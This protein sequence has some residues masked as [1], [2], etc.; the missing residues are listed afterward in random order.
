L[1]LGDHRIPPRDVRPTAAIHVEGKEACRLAA[2]ASRSPS[3]VTVIVA[4][5]SRWVIVASARDQSASTRYTAET[6]PGAP[7]PSRAAGVKPSQ[8]SRL[9][10]SDHG[11]RTSMSTVW[12]RRGYPC[13]CYCVATTPTY[14][15]HGHSRPAAGNKQAAKCCYLI[16][17]RAE[18]AQNV[19]SRRIE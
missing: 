6:A 18:V 1:R 17:S 13:L 4:V 3:P 8:N 19:H 7:E 2:A 5:L 16:Q 12:V 10:A 15:V 14:S 9:V 11:P